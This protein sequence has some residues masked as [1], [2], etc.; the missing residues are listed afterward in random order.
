MNLQIPKIRDWHH[1]LE[2]IKNSYTEALNR[3]SSIVLR[4]TV[5]NFG[6]DG[7]RMK[8]I[9]AHR[10]DKEKLWFTGQT[11]GLP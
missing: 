11:L 6:P 8:P 10:N 5:G 3:W 2:K 9:G 7:V 1:V 4:W